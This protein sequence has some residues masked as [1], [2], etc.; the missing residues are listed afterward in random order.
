[1]STF[2]LRVNDKD[3]DLKTHGAVTVRELADS[4]GLR[5]PAY[6]DGCLLNCETPLHCL[7]PYASLNA[8]DSRL[9]LTLSE[10][11]TGVSPSRRPAGLCASCCCAPSLICAQQNTAGTSL[12]IVFKLTSAIVLPPAPSACRPERRPSQHGSGGVAGSVLAPGVRACRTARAQ[13]ACHHSCHQRRRALGTL[14]TS[15][16]NHVLDRLPRTG[17]ISVRL[18]NR[19]SQPVRVL[20]S[21]MARVTRGNTTPVM[22]LSP[23]RHTNLT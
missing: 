1:M 10:I 18:R 3:V 22:A 11:K 16:A 9:H 8:P 23:A 20:T 6:A 7:L 12:G 19:S 5:L 14:P 21:I 17:S 13:R 15:R 2:Y 4:A